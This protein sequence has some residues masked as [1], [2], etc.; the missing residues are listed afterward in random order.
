MLKLLPLAFAAS[1]LCAISQAC[2]FHV[3]DEEHTS[4]NNVRR[5]T[6]TT[7][8]KTAIED[9]RP[10]NGRRFGKPQK[11]C[12]DGGHIVPASKC[13]DAQ[14]IVNGTG[15]FLIPGLIDNHVHLT[16]VQSLEDF[17]SYGC[18]TA[19]QMNCQNY[20]QC[21]LMA[22][23]EGLA[24]FVY[25]S[26]AAV[27]NGSLHDKQY[28]ARARDTLIY[29]S[30]DI[31]EWTRWQM[32]NGSHFLKITAEV[33][34][35]SLEQQIQMVHTSH[36]EFQKQTM[37]HASTIAA[38]EQAA[39][40]LTNGIQHV[41]DDG[42]LSSAVIQQILDQRQYVTTTLNI[43]E[44]GYREPALE[45]FLNIQPGSNRTIDNAHANAHLLHKAGIPILAGTDAVGS[46]KM[47]NTTISVPFGLTLH[48]EL[49]NLVK[50]VGM[51]PA[52]AINA[53]TREAARYHC[54]P[55]RG[56]IEIGKRADLV[57]LNSNP[58]ANISNTRDIAKIWT[59][60]VEAQVYAKN[61]TTRNPGA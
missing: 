36:N 21:A 29:P 50:Y 31:L 44:Y 7:S 38:Y 39:D 26:M 61:E 32:G 18:T 56:S 27:G 35:P 42:V 9:I 1:Q 52:E 20:T 53:A 54:V 45:K 60:G 8:V 43:F 2:P 19:M 11:I 17:T 4:I 47:G 37:T 5:S 33:A 14:N 46:L 58:L 51:S 57:M 16:D 49:E 6:S 15:K 59:L 12:L 3:G 40:S 10:F 24:S 48:F 41:P 28:P 55:D 13:A 34:G 25:A 30:T 22:R 23:Q